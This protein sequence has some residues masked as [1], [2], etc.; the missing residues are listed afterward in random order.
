MTGQHF[1]T[2]QATAKATAIAADIEQ[3]TTPN[4]PKK[5]GRKSTKIA[6]AYNAI[7]STPV[8]LAQF[9]LDHGVSEHVIKQRSRFAPDRTDVR[10][11]KN[12]KSGQ[13]EV[14]CEVAT[15]TPTMDAEAIVDTLTDVTA[16]DT[17]AMA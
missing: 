4:T 5:R 8:P 2:P 7:T 13:Y 11:G 6:D 15:P 1:A 16:A 14:W 9:C 10:V 12:R 3:A 17:S